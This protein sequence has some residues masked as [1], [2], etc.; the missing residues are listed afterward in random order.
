MNWFK[1]SAEQIMSRGFG[2]AMKAQAL[3]FYDRGKSLR[4]K[5]TT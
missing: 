4:E 5:R 1:K 3:H 2:Y